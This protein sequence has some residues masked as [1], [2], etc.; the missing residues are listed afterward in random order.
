MGRV[1]LRDR[2]A[3]HT[4]TLDTTPLA[5]V[6]RVVRLTGWN[7]V[8]LRRVDFQRGRESGQPAEA[9]LDLVRA[10]G[11]PVA[12]VGGERAWMFA[13][14]DEWKRLREGWGESCRW[15][16]ALGAGLTMSPTDPGLGDV[17]DAAARV[18]E[19]GDVAAEHGVRVAIEAFSQAAQLRTL[20]HV[21]EILAKAGH[22]AVGLL[23]DAYH[24]ARS[25]DGLAVLE[26]IR[27]EEIAYVQ[28]SDAPRD[29]S[30]PG[31]TADR[32]PPGQGRVPFREFFALITAKGYA[33]YLSYEAPNP[34]AWARPPEDVAREAALATRAVLPG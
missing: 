4:W 15:A 29:G 25:G 30:Q 3:L 18:R 8:E 17:A 28:Y 7:A 34:A 24:L 27:G 12:C 20:G 14:G 31:Q 19:V 5:E 33:G 32:L 21:R 26:D 11:L 22:P 13:A 10:S 2:L 16:R 9:V 6:L 23:V 1:P